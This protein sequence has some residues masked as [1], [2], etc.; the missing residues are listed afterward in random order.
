MT[1]YLRRLALRAG[2][3]AEPG[4]LQ[5]RLPS[6]FEPVTSG[7]PAGWL[8]EP[9]GVS[10]PDRSPDPLAPLTGPA[11]ANATPHP[12]LVHLPGAAS[13]PPADP[14]RVAPPKGSP[15]AVRAGIREPSSEFTPQDGSPSGEGA[16]R[17][18]ITEPAPGPVP[19]VGA[20]PAA[21]QPAPVNPPPAMPPDV[22]PPGVPPPD[23]MPP[24]VPPSDVMPPVPPP[25]VMAAP[26]S[27]FVPAP[28]VWPAA[29]GRAGDADGRAGDAH[30]PPTARAGDADRRPTGRRTGA[31]PALVAGTLGRGDP[32]RGAGSEVAANDEPVVRVTIGR[33]E[34]RAMAPAEPQAPA[35]PP[36]PPIS[37]D[38]YLNDREW[39]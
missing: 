7:Q 11:P 8:D 20:E 24:G 36:E 13:D 9:L 31:E 19:E 27:A 30:R 18:A 33:I 28:D 5:P 1:G 32:R 6:L 4:A 25:G 22:V 39:R 29:T 15:V 23:V 14:A 2:G 16:R 26:T 17:S 37:L 35:Q 12:D 38:Q 10:T 3:G 21:G 34:V